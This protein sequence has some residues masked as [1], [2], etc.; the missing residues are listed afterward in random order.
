MLAWT[1]VWTT[2]M[3]IAGLMWA[4]DTVPEIR[5]TIS[6]FLRTIPYLPAAMIQAIF[7][8]ARFAGQRGYQRRH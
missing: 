2:A 3:V 6:T 4:W 7:W 5:N 8:T 1:A